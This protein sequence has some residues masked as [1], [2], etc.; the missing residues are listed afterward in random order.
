VPPARRQ[1]DRGRPRVPN[2]LGVFDIRIPPLRER[3]GDV[4]PL[5]ETFLQE[6]GRSFGRPPASLTRQAR[7]A[8]LQYDW[9]GNVRELRNVLERAAILCEGALIDADHLNLQ[10]AARSP[11]TDT[12]DLS[13]VERSTITRVLEECRGN[14]TKAARRLGLSRTQLHLRIRKYGLGQA[15]TA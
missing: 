10:S 6:I 3:P 12:T 5:S 15:A 1:R 11:R 7:Q 2:R 13:V 9:P 8:L 14:K 4:V